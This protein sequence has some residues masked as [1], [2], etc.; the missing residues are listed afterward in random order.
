MRAVVEGKSFEVTKNNV[1]IAVIYPHRTEQIPATGFSKI[2]VC[3][4]LTTVN[5]DEWTF[6][7]HNLT[8]KKKR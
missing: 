6:D 7:A 5:A 2:E 8:G 1:P 3:G 4:E